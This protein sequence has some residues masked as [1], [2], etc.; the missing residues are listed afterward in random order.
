M[1]QSM[2]RELFLIQNEVQ[3]SFV[4]ILSYYDGKCD[5]N[6]SAAIVSNLVHDQPSDQDLHLLQLFA[7]PKCSQS[8]KRKMTRD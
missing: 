5:D 2:V 6:F 8:G 4:A 7:L 3:K 1:A